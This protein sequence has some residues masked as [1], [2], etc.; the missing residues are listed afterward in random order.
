MRMGIRT[1]QFRG[2]FPI[3]IHFWLCMVIASIAALIQNL[4]PCPSSLCI[5]LVDSSGRLGEGKTSQW[6][7]LTGRGRDGMG[8]IWKSSTHPPN[9]YQL[10]LMTRQYLCHQQTTM[11]KGRE[12]KKKVL[13]PSE[14]EERSFA[15]KKAVFSPFPQFPVSRAQF[16]SLSTPLDLRPGRREADLSSSSWSTLI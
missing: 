12:G 7:S 9:L 16:E 14:E 10:T 2:Y 6:L 5:W 1:P 4:S 8:T 15:K 3:S 11:Q 13:T